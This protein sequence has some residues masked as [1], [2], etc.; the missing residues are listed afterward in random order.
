M[1]NY[2]S[3]DIL[4]P[5]MVGPSSSHT[6]GAA[7]LGKIGRSIA[8]EEIRHVT[9]YLHGSFAAT[10]QGHGTDKALVAGML[11][12]DPHDPDLRNSFDIAHKKGIGFEFI[13]INMEDAHPNTV[14]MAITSITGKETIIIGSSIG[15]GNI[16]ITEIN[17]I[18]IEFTG[19]YPTL[20]TKHIDKPGVI[21]RVT[22][23]LA[24]YQVNVAFM[25]VYRQS[26]GKI[27]SMIVETDEG[28]PGEIINNINQIPDIKN[29]VIINPV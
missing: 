9:F 6:A 24:D 18:S 22:T 15:G 12:M 17:G 1:K 3:F 26:K 29:A 5:I 10:Y 21:A 7:R 20:I 27:A 19:Q 4:G 8:A 14:K 28:M 13:P 16:M 23:I 2:S 25:K 11:G